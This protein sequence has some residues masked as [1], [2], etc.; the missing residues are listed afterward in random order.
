M[1]E[2]YSFWAMLILR[3]GVFFLDLKVIA[4]ISRYTINKMLIGK[5]INIL[6]LNQILNSKTPNANKLAALYRL[7]Y[8]GCYYYWPIT[9]INLCIIIGSISTVV[10]K[11]PQALIGLVIYLELPSIMKIMNEWNIMKIM[12]TFL[13]IC[14]KYI[15]A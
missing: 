4:S 9:N 2:T 12:W 6:R 11:L 14:R 8:K 10:T 15:T 7:I 5:C 13:P 1:N 3:L